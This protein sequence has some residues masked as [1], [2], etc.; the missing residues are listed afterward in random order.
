VLALWVTAEE[1]GYA[2]GTWGTYRQWSDAGAQVR[3]GETAAFIVFYKELEFAG[4]SEAGDAATTTRLF[5][6]DRARAAPDEMR[7]SVELARM[8]VADAIAIV[9]AGEP[10]TRALVE[11]YM[12]HAAEA[13]ATRA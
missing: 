2:S 9:V 4:E 12:R 6:R 1:K 3:K 11:S 10:A 8:A 13:D 5:A 7:T